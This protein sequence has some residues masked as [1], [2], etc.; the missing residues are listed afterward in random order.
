VKPIKVP[1]HVVKLVMLLGLALAGG[2][3][4]HP[5]P[6][7]EIF[8]ERPK[9]DGVIN[10][11]PCMVK[12]NSGQTAVMASGEDALFVVEPGTYYLTAGSSN[13]FPTATKDSDWISG[14]VE[15]TLT[16]SQVMRLMVVP[17]RKGSAYAGGWEFRQQ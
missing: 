5:R 7:A 17:K 13:P 8:I 15:I 10:I 16:N 9:N 4:G 2:C 11:Y 6:Q 12:I 14:P 1:A 3:A